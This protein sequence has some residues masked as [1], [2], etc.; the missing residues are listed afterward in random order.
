MSFQV[1]SYNL[2]IIIATIIWKISTS[3]DPQAYDVVFTILI[4]DIYHTDYGITCYNV[5]NLC[6]QLVK[7]S[8]GVIVQVSM[9]HNSGF[10]FKMQYVEDKKEATEL[11]VPSG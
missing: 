4:T 9:Y 8:L 3:Y 1:Y 10:S 11:K 2:F 7:F 6:S 5:C